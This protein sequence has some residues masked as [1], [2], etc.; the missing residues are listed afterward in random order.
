VVLAVFGLDD[1][2]IEAGGDGDA[3]GCEA[4]PIDLLGAIGAGEMVRPV[5]FK[6]SG[7][8]AWSCEHFGVIGSGTD[9]GESSLYY[10][11]QS[12][13]HPINRTIYQVY[14][15]KRLGEKAPGVGKKTNLLLVRPPLDG[16]TQIEAI[17]H[18]GL[19]F[20]EECFKKHGPQPIGAYEMDAIPSVSRLTI[21]SQLIREWPKRDR[22]SQ[23][24]S[25]E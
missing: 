4:R 14:E 9:I 25:Q 1:E 6:I 3:I 21:P 24:P 7:D 16:Q 20:L 19:N 15:A 18:S 11:E 5:I 2:V 12:M 13:A 22:K 17:L 23:Q 8:T 10:R